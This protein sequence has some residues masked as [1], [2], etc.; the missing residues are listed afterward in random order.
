MGISHHQKLWASLQR[1]KI[2]AAEYW[3]KV[4]SLQA[5]ALNQQQ[6]ALD[7]YIAMEKAALQQNLVPGW[8]VAFED[9]LAHQKTYNTLM[10]DAS[11]STYS[12]MTTG[13]QDSLVDVAKGKW[14]D[15]GNVVQTFCDNAVKAWA[16]M[17]AQMIAQWVPR[18]L[19]RCSISASEAVPAREPVAESAAALLAA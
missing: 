19:H 5:D 17:I 8:K 16:G 4:Y 6:K 12:S 7:A 11:V 15:L 14:D 2:S 18:V 1:G 3:T 10:Y 9:I 13:M